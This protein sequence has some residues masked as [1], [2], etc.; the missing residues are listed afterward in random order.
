[1]RLRDRNHLNLPGINSP[2]IWVAPLLCVAICAAS[3]PSQAQVPTTFGHIG[4][5]NAEIAGAIIGAAAVIGVIVYFAIP[6]QKTIE[7]CVASGDGGLQLTANQHS[8][9]LDSTNLDLPSGHRLVL[10]G[11]P[12]HKHGA[13]RDFTVKKLIR[14]EGVC[15][16]RTLLVTPTLFYGVPILGRAIA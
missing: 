3:S 10:K 11:K 12:G 2:T 4:P 8:F 14:D 1:M 5:S 9:V 16:D 6:K 13:T 7:G 15:S